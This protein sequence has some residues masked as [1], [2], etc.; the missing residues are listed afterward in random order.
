MFFHNPSLRVETSNE[1][2]QSPSFDRAS[3]RE[4][5]WKIDTI[6]YALLNMMHRGWAFSVRYKEEPTLGDNKPTEQVTRAKH[7]PPAN[8]SPEQHIDFRSID[9]GDRQNFFFQFEKPEEKIDP[10]YVKLEGCSK[11]CGRRKKNFSSR[12][13]VF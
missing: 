7:R 12:K 6:M 9:M 11:I 3:V 13:T 2:N 1:Q 8:I 4:I 10:M 5:V